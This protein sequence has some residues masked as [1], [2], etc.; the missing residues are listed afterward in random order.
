MYHRLMPE[1]AYMPYDPTRSGSV[2]DAVFRRGL[3]DAFG[4]PFTDPQLETLAERYGQGEGKVSQDT[5]GRRIRG[6]KQ[7]RRGGD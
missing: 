7:G 4:M 6:L 5:P 3:W 1:D 2:T